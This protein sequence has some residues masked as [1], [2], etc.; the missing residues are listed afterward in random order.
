MSL[1]SGEAGLYGLVKASGIALAFKSLCEL[2]HEVSAACSVNGVYVSRLFKRYTKETPYQM[3]TRLKV[4]YAA[5]LILR[6]NLS[7]KQVGAQV[8]FDDPY[9]FSRVFK[10]VNGLSP[11]RY[12]T[13]IKRGS[14]PS[15]RAMSV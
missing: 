5:N 9:H 12:A 1:L 14:L 6:E 11:K 3:L 8:G 4:T 13:F 10:R 2:S 15:H 7:V